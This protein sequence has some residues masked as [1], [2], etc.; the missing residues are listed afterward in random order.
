MGVIDVDE[1]DWDVVDQAQLPIRRKHLAA[2]AGGTDL[3]CSLY[4]LGPGQ[5][6]WPYHYHTG[7]E[8]AMFVLDG[9]GTLRLDNETRQI[10]AGTYVAL[11]AAESGGHQVSNTSD[12]TL[13]YLMVSTMEEPDVTVYPDSDKIGIYAGA[14][15]GSAADRSVEGYYRR[16][17]RVEYWDGE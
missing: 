14:P 17:D 4:E 8:E 1:L 12:A 5:S 10:D 13:R 15:P 6:S 7:N 2:A 3:G 11:P 16:K 9:S